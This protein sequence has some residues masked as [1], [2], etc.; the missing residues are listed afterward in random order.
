[1]ARVK[2][3]TLKKRKGFITVKS[4]LRDKDLLYQEYIENGKTVKQ[5]ALEYEVKISF[6]KDLLWM[7]EIKKPGSGRFKK[8]KQLSADSVIVALYTEKKKTI[9]E[10]SDAT[11]DSIWTV[12]ECLRRNNVKVRTG[13]ERLVKGHPLLGT[14]ASFETRKKQ[15]IAKLKI[16]EEDWLGF[17]PHRK[18]PGAKRWRKEV[19]TRDHYI[20]KFCSSK[21][22]LEAHHIIPVSINENSVA[23]LSNGITLCKE[24]HKSIRRKE[25]SVAN[26]CR[27][28]LREY[29]NYRWQAECGWG[30]L[31]PDDQITEI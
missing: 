9:K 20:C 12:R 25:L 10:V 4:C 21:E 30:V 22:N 17:S 24:C 19:L 13:A 29:E 27:N 23:S 2:K 28:I 7:Y 16:A 18:R 15:S 11:G 5:L 14:S 3:G 6:V 26:Y 1:M 31:Y 8:K